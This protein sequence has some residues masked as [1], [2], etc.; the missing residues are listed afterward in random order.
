MTY[1]RN[2]CLCK[3]VKILY[4]FFW[5]HY[6]FTF[7][8]R[9]KVHLQKK[10]GTRKQRCLHSGADPLTFFPH[11]PRVRILYLPHCHEGG[12]DLTFLITVVLSH[13][14]CV[15][16]LT[17]LKGIMQW[18]FVC[19]Q[20]C[21]ALAAV[22]SRTLH[23]PQ[24][25]TTSPLAVPPRPPQPPSPGQPLPSPRPPGLPWAGWAFTCVHSEPHV[26]VGLS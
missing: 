17:Y 24:E 13:S 1:L 22:N 3:T 6:C 26:C 20:S 21:A 23:R 5:K 9:L 4:V 25:K 18:V 19:A 14:S 2:Y 15:V 8:R 16:Q 7:T 11:K 12:G 10:G